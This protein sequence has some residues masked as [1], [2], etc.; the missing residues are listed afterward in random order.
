MS[1][2][3]Y[4]WIQARSHLASACPDMR[5][6]MDAFGTR[7]YRVEPGQDLFPALAR[8]IAYQQLS[9]KAAGTIHGRFE[10]LFE[11]RRPLPDK[12][13]K[14]GFEHLRS[15]GLSRAKTLSILDLAQHQVDGRL[16]SLRAMGRLDDGQIIERLTQVRG[17]GPW[18]VQVYLIFSLGRPDVMPATDL[19]VQKGLQVV[20]GLGDLPAPKQVM[21][22]T[23]PFAPYRSAAAWYFWRASEFTQ[24][25]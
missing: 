20:Y 4:N 2:L 8:S 14:L 1:R 13:L 22:R 6:F 5:R 18:T 15:C 19:G 10:D 16:P 25:F 9:G 24:P 12:A 11:G 17:I 3:R 7:R 21:E 23:G